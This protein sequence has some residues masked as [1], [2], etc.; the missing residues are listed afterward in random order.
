V[1]AANLEV[2]VSV[3]Y[4]RTDFALQWY[5][6][7]DDWEMLHN[8]G[9]YEEQIQKL[10]TLRSIIVVRVFLWLS[11]TLA[12]ACFLAV[13]SLAVYQH[14]SEEPPGEPKTTSPGI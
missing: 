2:P 8:R 5:P 11:Y 13:A 1:P 7:S 6:R 4:Q 3:G 10:W 9:P 14:A 12:L